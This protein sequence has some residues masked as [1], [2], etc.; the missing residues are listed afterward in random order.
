MSQLPDTPKEGVDELFA[1]A[2]NGDQDAWRILFETCYPKV[3][4]VVRRKLHSPR[5][6][7]LYD[8]TDFACDVLKS[9]AA[10][11]DRL[12]F[13]TMD[14]LMAFLIRV[15]EHKLADEHRRQ[16][17]QKR[18]R[19]RE[20]HG[21]GE[22][23]SPDPTASEIAVGREQWEQLLAATEGEERQIIE[24]RRQGYGNEEIAQRLN[25][26]VRRVQRALKDLNPS[27]PSIGV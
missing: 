24:L 4:R 19:A 8:S 14:S 10:N 6:R 18:D 15:A 17:A 1:R 12:D 9:L 22:V 11:A 23:A 2:R 13:P 3:I 21:A 25:W 20:H 5:I 7:T 27:S 26:N 16:S